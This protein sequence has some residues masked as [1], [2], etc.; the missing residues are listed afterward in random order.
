[1]R[2]REL[3]SVAEVIAD[4]GEIPA[5]RRAAKRHFHLL[6]DWYRQNWKTIGVWLPLV[7]LRDVNDVLINRH[8]EVKDRSPPPFL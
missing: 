8:R 2:I 1:V 6:M 3:V 7:Q 4:L 5:P